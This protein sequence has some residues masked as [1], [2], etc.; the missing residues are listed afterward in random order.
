MRGSALT[1]LRPPM[2]SQRRTN[3]QRGRAVVPH[4]VTFLLGATIGFRVAGYHGPAV[5]FVFVADLIVLV[6]LLSPWYVMANASA[7]PAL[8]ETEV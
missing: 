3:A 8:R 6:T 5:T 7:W 4:L 1:R 2:G